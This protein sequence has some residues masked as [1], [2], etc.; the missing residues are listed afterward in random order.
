MAEKDDPKKLTEE[1]ANKFIAESDKIKELRFM[2]ELE[3]LCDKYHVDL[4]PQMVL[5]VHKRLKNF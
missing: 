1:Q 3:V 4:I 2:E 5:T